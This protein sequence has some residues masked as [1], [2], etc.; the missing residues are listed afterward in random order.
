MQSI[1]FL[2]YCKSDS[3]E[4]RLNSW[5]VIV[6]LAVFTAGCATVYNPATGKKEAIFISTEA[7]NAI[8]KQTAA[9]I[10]TQYKFSN[11]K[12][13]IKRLL[14][15]GAKIAAFSDRQDLKYEFHLI[16]AEDLNAFAI[17]GGRIYMFSGLYKL[18]DNDEI[19]CVLAHEAGHVAARHVIKK[20]QTALSYQILSTIALS[21]YTR[22]EDD[23]KKYA[24]YIAYAAATSFNIVMSG[25]SREDEYQADLLAIRYAKRSGYNPEAMI[26]S[27]KKLEENKENG[28]PAPY[29]FR[30]HPYISERIKRIR[31]NIDASLPIRDSSQ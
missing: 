31:S 19:A 20:L 26:G 4:K 7:E 30:S 11:D 27:L 10:A 25:Y 13:A 29:I 23:R 22:G 12:E 28:I 16:E 2:S 9:I 15:I 8:G 5:L 18:L 6:I 1:L 14:D 3:C 17:P 21:L 24:A